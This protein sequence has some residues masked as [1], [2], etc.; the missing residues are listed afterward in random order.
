MKFGEESRVEGEKNWVKN[1]IGKRIN[2][3]CLCQVHTTTHYIHTTYRLHT[4]YI[5][6][7]YIH[8]HYVSL[9]PLYKRLVRSYILGS[10]LDRV[11]TFR[12]VLKIAL[13]TNSGRR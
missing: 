3:E 6:I 12:D 7:T 5:Q 2:F 13:V 8:I 11:H 4:H 1:M 10:F 9:R